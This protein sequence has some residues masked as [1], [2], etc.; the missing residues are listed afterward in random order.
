[1]SVIDSNPFLKSAL[2]HLLFVK[3]HP[4]G[5]GNGRTARTLHNIKFTESFNQI[6][7]MKLKISPI[8]LS[9]SINI[10]QITYNKAI[11]GIYFDLEHD[12][13]EMI[14]Y[15][16]NFILNMYDEQLFKNSNMINDMDDV[17]KRIK[18]VK[19]RFNEESI[20]KVENIRIRR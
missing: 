19:E 5:D 3:I 16:F 10:N 9:Q 1:M 6:Y 12:N 18:K 20:K 2:I 14:N 8:N 11:N 13:N 4:Y 7:N 17:M 15:W